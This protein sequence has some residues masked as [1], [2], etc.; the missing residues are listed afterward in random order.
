MDFNIIFQ[1]RFGQPPHRF[2]FW[3][4][5]FSP[6]RHGSEDCLSL[7]SYIPGRPWFP[8]V[9][10]LLAITT[11]YKQVPYHR[12]LIKKNQ[13]GGLALLADHVWM[14]WRWQSM[15]KPE[16]NHDIWRSICPHFRFGGATSKPEKNVT[17]DVPCLRALVHTSVSGTL[18]ASLKKQNIWW[19]SMLASTCSHFFCFGGATSKLEKT[20]LMTFHAC[21]RLSTLPF[22]GCYEQAWKKPWPMTFHACEHLSTLPFRGRYGQTWKT[23]HMTF[24]A[25]EHSHLSTLPFRGR[26]EQA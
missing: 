1:H 20:W 19:R 18:R 8:I 23:K 10:D 4:W 2:F 13:C 7:D 25:Y 12:R 14:H 21:E 17:Y 9:K 26:Y 24:H 16:K 15:G 11:P 22:R 3:R 6:D 5:Y